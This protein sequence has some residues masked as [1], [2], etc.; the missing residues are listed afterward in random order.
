MPS[1]QKPAKVKI[2]SNKKPLGG[3]H[4][5]LLKKIK[6]Q[7]KVMRGSIMRDSIPWGK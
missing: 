4:E 7:K 6:N 1:G 3:K 5:N 2:T